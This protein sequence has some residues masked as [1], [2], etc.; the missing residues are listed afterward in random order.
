MLRVGVAVGLSSLFASPAR[1]DK[2]F[3]NVT[4]CDQRE[5]TRRTLP[6]DLKAGQVTCKKGQDVGED[7]QKRVVYC[8]T[9]RSVTVDGIVVAAD[10]YTLFHPNGKIYQTKV[11]KPFTRKLG[12]GSQV[13]CGLDHVSLD[14][15]GAL[16]VCDLA[17]PLG[18]SP[19][20]RV[21]EGVAFYPSGKTRGLMLDETHRA[22]GLEFPPGVRLGFDEQGKVVGGWIPKASTIGGLALWWDFRLWPNGKF[23]E[24]QLDQPAKIQG[25]DFPKRAKLAYRDDGTLERAEYIEKEGFMIHGEPWHDTLFL[26]FD[27]AGK[28]TK[29]RSEHWQAK[30]GPGQYRERLERERNKKKPRP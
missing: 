1:A 21:G 22:F 25:H 4:P 9:A 16:L 23:R 24:L 14:D 28:I 8:T 27:K 5:I 18:R 29:R 19:K 3:C 30:E 26:E 2:A 7:Q 15:Q 17:A 20:A 13:S 11:A 6:A 12:D 10:A